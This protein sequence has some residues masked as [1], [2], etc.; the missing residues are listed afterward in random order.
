MQSYYAPARIVLQNWD[1]YYLR[2]AEEG[3]KFVPVFHRLR[4]AYAALTCGYTLFHGYSRGEHTRLTVGKAMAVGRDGNIRSHSNLIR[5]LKSTNAT[6]D[7]QKSIK[8]K[9]SPFI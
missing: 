6:F 3:R 4:T 9:Q 1:N 8:F 2:E 7:T 5:I